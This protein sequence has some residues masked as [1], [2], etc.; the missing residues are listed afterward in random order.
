[1]QHE[2]FAQPLRRLRC[3]FPRGATAAFLVQPR[4][5]QLPL[6][7]DKFAEATLQPEQPRPERR[8]RT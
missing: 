1:M 4:N 3:M 2:L 8:S 6:W 5:V 7:Q